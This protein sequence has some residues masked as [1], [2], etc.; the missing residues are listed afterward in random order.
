MLYIAAEL[1][2]KAAA[3][4]KVMP[5]MWILEGE[6]LIHAM[7]NIPAVTDRLVDLKEVRRRH[8]ILA[9]WWWRGWGMGWMDSAKGGGRE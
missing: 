1:C 6:S 2:I 4:R 5:E 3:L 9:K 8:R 7:L